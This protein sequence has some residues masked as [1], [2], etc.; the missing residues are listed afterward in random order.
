M[1]V[2]LDLPN[3]KLI[4]LAIVVVFAVILA[5][6]GYFA[7]S[8]RSS[9]SSLPQPA[10]V[11]APPT[12]LSASLTGQNL[13]AYDNNF[14]YVPY[15]SFSYF[16]SNSSNITINATLLKG[17][18]PSSVYLL[19]PY[20][21]CVG[22]SNAASVESILGEYLYR[23]G[24]VPEPSYLMNVSQAN[25]TSIPGRSIIIM[26]NGLMPQYMFNKVI[27]TNT[28]LLQYLLNR[29]DSIVYVGQNFTNV[30]LDTGV[31]VPNPH[32][33]LY[34]LTG[35]PQPYHGS[36]FY[37]ANSTYSL[38]E[39]S[40]YGPLT[41]VNVANGSI[42][43]FPNY[44]SAWPNATSASADIARAVSMMFW[45]PAYASGST[46]I[47]L[48]PYSNTTG[49][50]GVLMGSPPIQYSASAPSRLNAGSLRVVVYNSANY[51]LSPRSRYVVLA[52]TPS[53]SSNGSISM[54]G[55]VIPGRSTSLVLE[56]DT[57]SSVPVSVQPHIS[58]YGLNATE[59]TEIPLQY[60]NAAGNFTFLKSVPFDIPPG[61]YIAELQ[62]FSGRIYASALFNVSPIT[63][64]LQYANYSSNRYS[65]FLQS[66]GL[67]LSGIG[68]TISVNNLYKSEG[69][70]DHGLIN[71]TL[72]KGSPTLYG[73]LDFNISML[74][75]TFTYTAKHPAP[76]IVINQQ[77]VI[78]GIVGIIVLVLVTVV[79]APNRDEF[80]IDVPHLPKR[81]ATPVKIKSSELVSIFDKLNIY[82]HW[83]YMP[84]SKNELR[85]GIASNIRYNGMPVNL[86]YNNIDLILDQLVAHGDL[87]TTGELYAPT[88]WLSQSG[89]DLEYLATFKKLRLY[90]VAHAYVFTDIGSSPVAD[91]VVAM[92]GE[93]AYIV[94]YSPTSKFKDVPVYK[95]SKTY[96]A[97]LNA[98]RMDEFRERIYS[99]PSRS[100]E[101]FKMYVS[102][103][104]IT[105]VDADHPEAIE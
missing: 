66:A 90:M 33:P 19:N 85:A 63:I 56:V 103:G 37:F 26:L 41:Y 88:A 3:V 59:V 21:T 86:T 83:R 39:G 7:L 76:R 101:I 31:I 34:L 49:S 54:P 62:S 91:M 75:T 73:S 94:I 58:V 16:S 95:N 35:L 84:L 11:H 43:A 38:T 2:V 65:F 6:M 98:D 51:S 87:A 67:P 102:S 79:K 93:R 60:F 52:A 24:V 27:G 30:L 14:S 74:S 68:Y 71:Y 100:N 104:R 25:L 77:Y 78:L 10:P 96:L 18:P 22:C 42:V 89:Y 48:N 12:A 13:L 50:T 81:E 97:F 20:P 82:Y 45:L 61:R 17:P 44:L 92:H 99:L 47:K 15:A 105:L 32:L 55:S 28:T 1:P 64:T 69:A 57:G 46:T 70:I 72:P 36:G 53:Y 23:Y 8:L 9:L 29:G 4:V 80:Y 5:A 40:N